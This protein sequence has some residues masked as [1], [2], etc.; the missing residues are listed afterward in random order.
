[1][2][3]WWWQEDKEEEVQCVQEEQEDEQKEQWWC[4]KL[5]VSRLEG[6]LMVGW[7][8]ECPEWVLAERC[9]GLASGVLFQTPSE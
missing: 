7:L 9:L 6:P 8:A 3:P 5:S 1:L 2:V 4:W